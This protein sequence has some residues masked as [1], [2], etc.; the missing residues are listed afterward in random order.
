MVFVLVGLLI[1]FFFFV[2]KP[3]ITE[4]LIEKG[5]LEQKYGKYPQA[6]ETWRQVLQ[7]DPDNVAHRVV[8]H[9]NL[10][11][12]LSEQI[13]EEKKFE[14]LAEFDKVIEFKPNS[15]D[16]YY[17]KGLK[18]YYQQKQEQAIPQFRQAIGLDPKNAMVYYYL[19]NALSDQKELDEAI[20][21][22]NEAT[23]LDSTY[24]RAY[25]NLGVA[26]QKKGK[27][28]EAIKKYEKA[29]DLDPNYVF[30]QNNLEEAKRKLARQPQPVVEKLPSS[31][32]KLSLR[33]RSVVIVWANLSSGISKGTGWV[34]KKESDRAWIVTNRH[35]VVSVVGEPSEQIEVEFYSE[36]NKNDRLRK[37]AKIS[38]I[39]QNT[40]DL[41]LALLEVANV[42]NDIKCLPMSSK[43]VDN[44]QKVTIIG[45]PD[46]GSE[47]TNE[48]GEITKILEKELQLSD[49]SSSPGNSGSPVLNEDGQVVGLVKFIQPDDSPDANTSTG[50]FVFAY[51][52]ELVK[53]KLLNWRISLN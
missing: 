38:Q 32:D 15:A 12:A 11:I 8:A 51:K 47:W 31:N 9:R 26:L 14:G 34:V 27:L 16:A 21:Q 41:D 5:N 35:V 42:P 52:I 25:N 45:H 19:G 17:S 46:K 24:S 4:Q 30:A 37:P 13:S 53:N 33:R 20:T 39:T 49:A 44:N 48:S 29:S 28:E 50:G 7:N 43:N 40:E 10:G 23:E 2:F 1:L 6:E 22:Y 36:N 18:L 3:P